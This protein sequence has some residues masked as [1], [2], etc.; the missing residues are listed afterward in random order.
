MPGRE[1]AFIAASARERDE[2][3]HALWLSGCQLDRRLARDAAAKS[4]RARK[5]AASVAAASAVAASAS[6]PSSLRSPP[7]AS[8]P[9]PAAVP[10]DAEAASPRAHAKSLAVIASTALPSPIAADDSPSHA[11]RLSRVSARSDLPLTYSAARSKL[12]LLLASTFSD[13][14]TG[15]G[16]PPAARRG[17][18]R[19]PSEREPLPGLREVRAQCRA[20][21]MRSAPASP[22]ASPA[23]ASSP[24]AAAALSGGVERER[25]ELFAEELSEWLLAVATRD[26]LALQ[27]VLRELCAAMSIL[28]ADAA[29]GVA[30]PGEAEMARVELLLATAKADVLA[31]L[32][33]FHQLLASLVGLTTAASPAAS[34]AAHAPITLIDRARSPRASMRRDTDE[35]QPPQDVAAGNG[36]ARPHLAATM[37]PEAANELLL[38]RCAAVAARA[39]FDVVGSHLTQFFV[40]RARLKDAELAAAIDKLHSLS[41]A[42]LGVAPA[43]RLE[44]RGGPRTPSSEA[45]REAVAAIRELPRSQHPQS[46]F[47]CL[48]NMAQAICAAV[49]AHRARL[50]S[51]EDEPGIVMCVKRRGWGM[52]RRRVLTLRVVAA[53]PTTCCCSSPLSSSA[54]ACRSSARTS[55]S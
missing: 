2:W 22:A 32:S 45:Y 38:D 23:A 9:S 46:K 19:V 15:D 25:V 26:D 5:G 31:F 21:L 13:M 4:K 54:R 43:L 29:L 35:K 1:L 12:W 51:S 3:I 20:L 33:H 41:L 17:A 24:V 42:A 6:S 16:E 10:P 14:S 48:V 18:R 40:A 53:P 11:R 52:R 28:A 55:P 37:T 34:P 30:E 36:E 39:V 27:A 44:H 47:E 7:R 50:S 49:D 8:S